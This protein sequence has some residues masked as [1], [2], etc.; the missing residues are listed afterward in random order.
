MRILWI[1]NSPTQRIANDMGIKVD[2]STGWLTGFAN[3][4]EEC[5]DIDLTV[6][7]PYLGAKK[8]ISG[9]V[10]NTQ[11]V[12][13]YQQK[14]AKGINIPSYKANDLTKKHISEIIKDYKP[15]VLH[16]FGT[17]YEHSLAAA[18]LFNKPDR[19]LV[20]IQ[21][22]TSACAEHYISGLP[23]KILKKFAISNIIRGNILQEQ[24]KFY[25]RGIYEVQT[26]ELVK[27]VVGRTDW[28]D[29]YTKLINP[30]IN[31]YFC[32]ESLRDEF[33]KHEWDVSKCEKY[34][35]FMSQASY[36]IKGIH[37]M[38]KALPNIIQYFPDTH[39]YV[40][41]ND[42][43]K[44]EGIYNKLRISSYGLYI[45]DLI[46]KHNLE[47]HITFTGFLNETKMCERY[48]KSN[49]F[50]SASTIENSPNSLGEAMLL[51]VPSVSSDVGGVKNIFSHEVDGYIYQHDAPYMLSYYVCKI[52]SDEK[53]SQ[54][55]S[56]KARKHALNNHDRDVN[57]KALLNIYKDIDAKYKERKRQIDKF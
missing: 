42:L 15:D 52:F 32:N 47:K 22:L 7:F 38:I 39:L 34:S 2:D 55:F 46:K 6:A 40:A 56:S 11:Y 23:L 29:A 17:E 24:N 44:T 8:K 4:L 54:E 36:P 9:K 57:A 1:A 48:L 21:G 49:V 13:F 18:Q 12:S 50:V 5:T 37:F 43:T 19:T 10:G 3:R 45:R 33:Y 35:I 14:I 16:I 53:L 41:G 30:D 20:H 26:L 51:G 28:D 31:Y 25:K 27:N